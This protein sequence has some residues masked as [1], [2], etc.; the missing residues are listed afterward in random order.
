[1][2]L[3]AWFQHHLLPCNQPSRKVPFDFCLPLKMIWYLRSFGSMSLHILCMKVK[4]TYNLAFTSH[5]RLINCQRMTR[6]QDSICRNLKE[7]QSFIS[8]I[9]KWLEKRQKNLHSHLYLIAYPERNKITNNN[10]VYWNFIP[11]AVSYNLYRSFW[12]S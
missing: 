12:S 2:I 10:F 11:S 6:D 1:M 3:Q 8:L 4:P 7:Y 9:R 5:A